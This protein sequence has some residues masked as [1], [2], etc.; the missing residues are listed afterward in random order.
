MLESPDHPI[1]PLSLLVV[2]PT[3]FCNI[4]CDYCYLATRNLRGVIQPETLDKLFRSVF[5]SSIVRGGFSLVWHAGEPL[6]LPIAF[7]ER[8]NACLARHNARQLPVRVCFQTNGMLVTDAWCEF[9]IE[10]GARVG[11]SLDGPR[12]LHDRHRKTRGKRGTF[13]RVM[14]GVRRLQRA[15]VAFS[16]I[17]VLTRESLLQPRRIFSFFAEEG[18]TNVG[19]NVEELEGGHTSTSIGFEEAHAL[20]YR[21]MEEIILLREKSGIHVR[22]LD[23]FGAFLKYGQPLEIAQQCTP[24]RIISVD[25]SGNLSTFSPE[26]LGVD[27]CKYGRLVFGNLAD[28]EIDD[29]LSNDRFRAVMTDVMAGVDACRRDC[30]Y[31]TVCGGG[32]P[33]NKLFE[34]GSFAVTETT[35][36]RSQI[37]A[38]T[39][40]LLDHLD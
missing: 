29:I 34:H 4:D 16:V 15:G 22:E 35:Y 33:A 40:V 28:N 12:E 21:F 11:V 5:A 7:Y 8:A 24:L 3:P 27:T 38:L 36:C 2:Q 31:F 10:S 9:F 23:T 19:F 6:V 37:K 18:I 1:G 30:G 20:Y 25:Y 39:D 13:D 17:C 32:A 14:A 26:M